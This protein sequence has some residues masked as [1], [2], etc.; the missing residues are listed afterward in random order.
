MYDKEWR[1]VYPNDYDMGRSK[2]RPFILWR[3]RSITMGIKTGQSSKNLIV[4]CA[5]E[6]GIS[7]VYQCFIN[8]N[9]ELDR[10]I[11]YKR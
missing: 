5:K 9:D 1:M 6:A 2:D 7:Y 10:R 11:V 3:P 4:S 8:N